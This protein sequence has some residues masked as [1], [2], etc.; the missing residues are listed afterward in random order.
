MRDK[1]VFLQ[2][3][4]FFSVE[5]QI[6]IS[7]F[8]VYHGVCHP[9][10]LHVARYLAYAGIRTYHL[11]RSV[12]ESEHVFGVGI[13]YLSFIFRAVNERIAARSDRLRRFRS[14]WRTADLSDEDELVRRVA[15]AREEKHAAEE[16]ARETAEATKACADAL[17]AIQDAIEQGGE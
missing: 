5:L 11:I 4:A 7:V 9:A 17:E 16:Y 15:L 3:Q 1:P 10:A 13:F 2:I 8:A 14:D 12:S 6:I